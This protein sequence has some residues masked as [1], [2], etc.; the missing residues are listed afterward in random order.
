MPREITDHE[1]VIEAIGRSGVLSE[2]IEKHGDHFKYELDLELMVYGRNYVNKK[3]G[4]YARLLIYGP[5]EEIIRQGEWRENTFY[6]LIDGHLDVYVN[7]NQGASRQAGTIDQ[8]TS[9]GEMSLL[10]GQPASA[11]VVVPSGVEATVL[12]VQRP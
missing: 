5:C 8:Q 11:S 3:V 6:V 12:E 1:A 7:G 9:F 4:P 10:A 2:L